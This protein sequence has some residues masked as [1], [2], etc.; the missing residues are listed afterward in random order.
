MKE[1]KANNDAI[2]LLNAALSHLQEA[3]KLLEEVDLEEKPKK[4]TIEIRIK[5][6]FIET[7]D[8]EDEE[9]EK[10]R[11]ELEEI[12]NDATRE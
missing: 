12:I 11:K 6:P 7:A 1:M 10:L 4:A 9:L 2:E 3:R 5:K 8:L